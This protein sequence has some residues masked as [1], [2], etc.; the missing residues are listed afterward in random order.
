[1]TWR[2][3]DAKPFLI[4]CID[5]FERFSVIASFLKDFS[6]CK[7]TVGFSSI[8]QIKQNVYHSV[9][10]YKQ[11]DNMMGWLIIHHQ[12][13]Q[14][15]RSDRLS[16]KMDVKS[17][18]LRQRRYRAL[19]FQNSHPVLVKKG[20]RLWHLMDECCR[21]IH[22]RGRQR[23]CLGRHERWCQRQRQRS[24]QQWWSW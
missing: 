3:V 12:S 1:M 4:M 21:L 7:N 13:P 18:L 17:R 2:Q 6:N 15:T 5:F 16:H 11:K 9:L 24:H 19:L 10:A 8:F 22:Q 23:C 20:Y 14:Q